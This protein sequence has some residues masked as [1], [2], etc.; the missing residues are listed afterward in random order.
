MIIFR[1]K[2]EHVE[3]ANAFFLHTQ[4]QRVQLKEDK[5]HNLQYLMIQ[6]CGYSI[7]PSS[8]RMPNGDF[9]VA[10]RRRDDDPSQ[11]NFIE[12]SRYNKGTL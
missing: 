12:H 3:C 7:M 2:T 10:L 8:V 6:R 11:H 4:F 5:L 9:L 1:H